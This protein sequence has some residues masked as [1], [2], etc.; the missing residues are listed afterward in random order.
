MRSTPLLATV[1]ALISNT[2]GGFTTSLH[3]RHGHPKHRSSSSPSSAMAATE[4]ALFGMG[5]F[6]APQENFRCVPGVTSS[7]SGYALA[8]YLGR[9][10]DEVQASIRS[11]PASYFSICSG[12]GRTEAILLEY[13]PSVISYRELVECFW[14]RHDASLYA[15]DKEDQYR[16]VVWPLNEDQQS[17]ALE[18]I[19]DRACPAYKQKGLGPPRTVIADL[20]LSVVDNNDVDDYVNALFTPA[21]AFHQSF[22]TKSKLKLGGFALATLLHSTGILYVADVGAETVLKAT[23]LW[24]VVEVLDLGGAAAGSLG[25]NPF[26]NNKVTPTTIE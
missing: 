14:N 21:E 15:E 24:M 23:W 11:N 17:T 9:E 3:N 26:A 8:N 13:D 4:K 16:S 6:W 25:L 19:R 1:V 22:W 20:P 7:T 2:T 12:D 10:A 5:C 18:E